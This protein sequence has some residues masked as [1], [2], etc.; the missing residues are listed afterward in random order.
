LRR[1]KEFLPTRVLLRPTWEGKGSRE[2]WSSRIER[3]PL[4]IR[5]RRRGCVQ[6]GEQSCEQVD[7]FSGGN[8]DEIAPSFKGGVL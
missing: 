2:T 1:S 8:D 5:Y 4:Q 3:P 6:E 7:S